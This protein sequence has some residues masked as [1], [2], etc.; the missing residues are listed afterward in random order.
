[1]KW[2]VAFSKSGFLWASSWRGDWALSLWHQTPC[3]LIPSYPPFTEEGNVWSSS[4]Q[5]QWD[6]GLLNPHLTWSTN[7]SHSKW[8]PCWPESLRKCFSVILLNHWGE[9]KRELFHSSSTLW[10]RKLQATHCRLK[11]TF[12]EGRSMTLT[13]LFYVYDPA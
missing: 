3:S 4:H 5:K 10:H 1:M 12:W 9:K 8:Q 2:P 13:V 6:P 11:T 7:S